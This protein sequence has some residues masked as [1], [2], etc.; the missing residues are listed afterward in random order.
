MPWYDEVARR[1]A[2]KRERH[3]RAD[4]EAVEYARGI[5]PHLLDALLEERP[6]D[7]AEYEAAGQL[8]LLGHKL[9]HPRARGNNLWTFHR[10]GYGTGT[11]HCRFCNA[12]LRGNAVMGIDYGRQ[13]DQVARHT[14]QCALETLAGIRQSVKPGQP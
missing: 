9:A 11:V 8:A 12:Q 5:A 6:L 10:T 4:R 3:K 2:E 7:P 14:M 1:E 13:D